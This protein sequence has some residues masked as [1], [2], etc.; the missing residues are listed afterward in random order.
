MKHKCAGYEDELCSLTL[1]QLTATGSGATQRRDLWL[2]G[3]T[4]TLTDRVVP[5][6]RSHRFSFISFRKHVKFRLF[7][8]QPSWLAVTGVVTDDIAPVTV[9]VTVRPDE[10]MKGR[11][12]SA[13]KLL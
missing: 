1:F 13:P 8:P 6:G 11:L 9:G 7:S 3:L 2:D 5:S 10:R 12:R 4:G